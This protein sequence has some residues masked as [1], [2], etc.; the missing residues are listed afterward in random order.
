MGL[1]GPGKE[2]GSGRWGNGDRRG[3]RCSSGG[4]AIHC[5]GCGRWGWCRIGAGRRLAVEMLR[6]GADRRQILRQL[7]KRELDPHRLLNGQGNLRQEEGIEPELDEGGIE[8]V[9]ANLDSRGVLENFAK[10][11]GE[12]RSSRRL[13]RRHDDGLL[14]RGWPGSV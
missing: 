8:I 4:T 11:G 5:V 2:P 7:A 12:A 14:V 10:I 1:R 3:L 9:L 6:D 13:R